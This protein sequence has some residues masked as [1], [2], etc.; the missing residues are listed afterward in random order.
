M[1]VVWHSGMDSDFQSR[2]QEFE[3]E[4]G[5]IACVLGQGTLYPR[6]SLF[7]QEFKWDRKGWAVLEVLYI[8]PVGSSSSLIKS[9]EKFNFLNKK[10][11]I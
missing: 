3:T 5:R 8:L 7:T 10:T 1:E 6:L 2:G 11:P 9:I 4:A